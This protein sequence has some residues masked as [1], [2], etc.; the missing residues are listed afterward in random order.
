MIIFPILAD[1]IILSNKFSAIN[2]SYVIPDEIN[3][4]AYKDDYNK[5]N[6]FENNIPLR[7]NFTYWVCETVKKCLQESLSDRRKKIE[8]LLYDYTRLNDIADM[9]LFHK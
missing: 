9:I 5:W 3:I 1:Q 7:Q 2:I 8:G 4:M 6:A